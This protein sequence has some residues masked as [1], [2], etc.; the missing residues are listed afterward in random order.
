MEFYESYLSYYF[1]LFT[2]T[3]HNLICYR[4]SSNNYTHQNHLEIPVLCIVIEILLTEE[5]LKPTCIK[6]A[7]SAGIFLW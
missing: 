3:Y 5:M 2:L 1:V 6:H 4:M 7:P